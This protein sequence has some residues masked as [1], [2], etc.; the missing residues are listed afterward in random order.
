MRIV[1][2]LL[3]KY[4]RSPL[5]S[6]APVREERKRALDTTQEVLPDPVRLES[7]FLSIREPFLTPKPIL[8]ERAKQ[9]IHHKRRRS[10]TSSSH[11]SS[12]STRCWRR[13]FKVRMFLKRLCNTVQ[14][15]FQK[16]SDIKKKKAQRATW[17][18]SVQEVVRYLL[19]A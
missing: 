3:F 7:S 8:R 17:W 18:F 6:S 4:V 11:Q 2:L 1:F 9:V 19:L 10:G 15:S 13:T 16:K 12:N 14:S 5:F